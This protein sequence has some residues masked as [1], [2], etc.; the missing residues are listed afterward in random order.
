[1]QPMQLR[2]GYF[3]TIEGVEGAGKST[4]AKF[5]EKFL[6]T[7]GVEFV[8]TREP[9][10]TEIAEKIR[11]ILLDHHQETMHPDTELLLYFAGR[12][13]HF[14]KFILPALQMGKWVICD[15][16]TD[17]SYAYQGGGRNI[18]ARRI[19]LL[20]QFVQG[21][22]RPDLTLLMDV[23]VSVGLERVRKTRELDRFE[24]E[25]E[26]FFRRVRDCYL[27]R[28]R[29]EPQRFRVVD[30]NQPPAN[31]NQQLAQIMSEIMVRY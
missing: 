3:I 30:A 16:F 19:A 1:M 7:S 15:R 4:A 14:N 23:D 6:E 20:E 9:G 31:V 21:D 5:L 11:K 8:I 13:Q 18:D 24:V 22:L 25:K 28:V 10:G 12:A 26:E 29:K 17:A 2:R 27:D